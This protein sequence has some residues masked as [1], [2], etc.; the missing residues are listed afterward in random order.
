MISLFYTCVPNILIWPTVPEIQSVRLKLVIM[1]HFLPFH[2]PLKIQKNKIWK[3][4][5]KLLEIS[6]FYMCT[7]TTIIW[8]TVTEVWNETDRL[9]CHFGPL[10]T[11]IYPLFT[12]Y[13]PTPQAK[14]ENQ[15]FEKMKK[16]SGDVIIRYICTKNH[17]HKISLF[18]EEISACAAVPMHYVM[19]VSNRVWSI[20]LLSH[21]MRTSFL[22][23]VL[24]RIIVSEPRHWV[25][26]SHRAGIHFLFL[27]G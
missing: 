20:I 16:A 7:K 1:G 21:M 4:W 10:F 11:L 17:N 14:P 5:K 3:K 24:T 6:S 9:F 13:L 15:N 23:V 12:H 26:L 22:L 8:G 2:L 27:R 18:W 19:D 25:I